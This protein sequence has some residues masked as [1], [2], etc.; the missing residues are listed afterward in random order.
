[1][2]RKFFEK[3]LVKNNYLLTG[4]KVS[5]FYRNLTRGIL[6]VERS[7]TN[8]MREFIDVKSDTFYR[9]IRNFLPKTKHLSA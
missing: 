2:E 3:Y 8:N 4:K 1:M 7:E 5:T 9:L 6:F